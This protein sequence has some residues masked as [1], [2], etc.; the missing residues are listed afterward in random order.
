MATDDKKAGGAGDRWRPAA[1]RLRATGRTFVVSLA[2]VAATAAAGL[3]LTQF[4]NVTPWS[5]AFVLALFGLLLA[6]GGIV[7]LLYISTRLASASST[8]ISELTAATDEDKPTKKAHDV[9]NDK[10]NGLLAGFDDIGA[11]ATAATT[12]FTQ[13]RTA[14][15]AY[16]ENPNK[17]T[18]NAALA[19]QDVAQW[20]R[21]RLQAVASAASYQRL[22]F[23]FD[24]SAE[25]LRTAAVAAAVGVIVY[26]WAVTS[27]GGDD[28]RVVR[29]YEHI[30][31]TAPADAGERQRFEELLGC[32][33][34]DGV[35][36][37]IVSDADADPVEAITT[38]SDDCRSVKLAV[39]LAADGTFVPKPASADDAAS[40]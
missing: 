3:G 28:L 35:P 21:H 36:A 24:D 40:E 4:G 15:D 26:A 7:A 22:R 14:L 5:G 2:S 13:E 10:K 27:G 6:T 37:I 39:A 34:A 20:Y 16:A 19:R 1:D 18:R 25:H 8:S 23:S 33:A 17:K 11:L 32:V 38:G 30:T 12:A 31:I 29:T 9:V